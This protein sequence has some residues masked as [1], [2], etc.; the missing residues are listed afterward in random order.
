M[1]DLET[2]KSIL[3][4]EGITGKEMAEMLGLSYGSY[5]TMTATGRTKVPKW[6]KAFIAG[7]AIGKDPDLLCMDCGINENGHGE[8]GAF[9]ESCVQEHHAHANKLKTDSPVSK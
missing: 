4:K 1:K 9:C 8:L 5:R 6:V 2:M 7:W 3:S